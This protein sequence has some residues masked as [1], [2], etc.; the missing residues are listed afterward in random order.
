MTGR[1]AGTPALA[2]L[3]RAGEQ[4]TEAEPIADSIYMVKDISNAYL[5]TTN[6]GDLLVNTGF[7]ATAEKNRAMLA[8]VRSGPLR[9]IVL[10]Q[11]HPDHYGGTPVLKEDGTQVLAERRFTDTWQYF[12]DLHPYLSARSGKLWAFNRKGTG[13]PPVPP[14]VVPDVVVDG[15]YGFDLGE[16]RFELIS[17]PG[18]ETLCGLVVWIPGERVAFTGNL[19][20]PIFRAVPNLVTIRGD[21]PR[22]VMR[23]LDSLSLVRDLGAELL[24]TGHGAPIRG[25]DRIRA[26]LT[27]MHDAVS[28]VKDATIAGMNAGKTVHELMRGITLPPALAIGEYHGKLS[29]LVRSIWEEHS[30]WFHFDSTTSLYGVP[31][32]AVDGDLVQLAGG[33]AAIGARAQARL[34]AGQPLEALHLLDIALGAEPDDRGALALKK[35]VIERL[36]AE[37]TGEN[38][39][40]TMWLR[41][42]IAALDARLSA[43]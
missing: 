9:H 38:L 17:A 1:T 15:R 18:G 25:A 8:K 34:G 30:G 43:Q 31:R 39:S 10:T 28:Y 36:L 32:S 42:E 6:D 29:W 27:L 23:Y 4:Q 7:M 2:H 16:R 20:G 22:L 21:R 35:A 12:H 5:V 19:F 41:S 37:A 14:R 13:T 40:E 33:V 11:A 26:D 3:I 24:I